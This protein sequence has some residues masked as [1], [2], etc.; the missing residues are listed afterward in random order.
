MSRVWRNILI[1]SIYILLAAIVGGYF[2]G[3]NIL[4]E[5]GRNKERCKAIKVKLLDSS[6]NK[7]VAKSDVVSLID[8]YYGG[9]IGM[10]IDS[11]NLSQLESLLNRRSVVKESQVSITRDGL[12]S[13]EISQRRPVIRVEMKS[14]GYYIDENAYVFPLINNYSSYVPIVSGHLPIDISIEENKLV[15]KDSVAWVLK[16]VNLG[17]FLETN[18]FWNAQVEQ[19]YFT[20]EH[21]IELYTRVGEQKIL[22]GE[23]K[24]VEEKFAKLYSFYKNATGE[25]GWK[26]YSTI[27]LSFKGQIVCRKKR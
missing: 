8:N 11:I 10:S 2:Y 20:E 7:F 21:K 15:G 23:L 24:D 5:K 1:T 14:G 9:V 19:I 13:V 22:F 3:A 27:D 6:L 4:R 25:I 18:P 26:K 17:K 16:L 12:M